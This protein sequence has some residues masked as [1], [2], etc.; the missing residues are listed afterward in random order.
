MSNEL[1]VNVTGD[2]SRVAFLENGVLSEVFVERSKDIGIVGNIYKGKVQRVLPGMNAAFVEIGHERAAFLYVTDFSQEIKDVE[3]EEDDEND[4]VAPLPEL[5][6]EIPVSEKLENLSPDLLSF[7]DEKGPEDFPEDISEEEVEEVEEGKKP[8]NRRYRWGGRAPIQHLLKPNQEI[9]VQVTRAPLGTKGARI[10][11]HISI[12]GRYLVFM[13]TWNK[14]GVSKKIGTFEERKR[15]RQILRNLKPAQGGFIVRTAA[16]GVSEEQLTQDVNFLVKLWQDILQK[17]DASKAPALIQPELD[18]IL[19]AT[20]DLYG[21]GIDKIIVDER[22]SFDKVKKFTEHLMPELS[23]KLMFY[24]ESTPVFDRYGIESEL[25]RALGK[26]VWLKSGGYLIIEQTE[27]LT[28]IDVNTGRFVGK[29]NLE[30]TIHKNNLEAVEE[31]AYQLRIR[32]LGGII[33]LDFIDMEKR[34]N[35][36]SVYNALIEALKKDRAK[37][38]IT[39]ISDL[40]LIEMTRKRARE[41]LSRIL[42]EACPYCESRGYV[43]SPMTVVYEIFRQIHREIPYLGDKRVTLGVNPKVFALLLNGE[44]A[45][46]EILEKKIGRKIELQSRENYH[47]EEFNLEGL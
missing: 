8:L 3:E 16:E 22:D 14:L 40:G 42:C 43:K 32:N 41:S 39:K 25:N 4:L 5:T 47:I 27:A 35:R 9:M 28:T 1:V 20:R 37:T 26:K 36:N 44:R 33:I 6:D 17:S 19:R 13:P 46:L 15:L 23:G 30:E 31:I 10:T 38:T 29:K 18:V 45:E 21:M 11:S 7:P 34:G 24:S 2:E 12:P